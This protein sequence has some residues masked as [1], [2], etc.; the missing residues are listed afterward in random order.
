MGKKLKGVEGFFLYA[1]FYFVTCDGASASQRVP[2]PAVRRSFKSNHRTPI[3]SHYALLEHEVSVNI[4]CRG[5]NLN[6]HELLNLRRD[7]KKGDGHPIFDPLHPHRSD[8]K[9]KK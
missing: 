5:K 1:S 2:V 3:T 4:L 7:R 9:R 8:D 6:R